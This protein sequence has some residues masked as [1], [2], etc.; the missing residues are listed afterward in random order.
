MTRRTC[1]PSVPFNPLAWVTLD[2]LKATILA[3]A[4]AVWCANRGA[5]KQS[6]QTDVAVL[7]APLQ[8]AS[9]ALLAITLSPAVAA[10]FQSS[11]AQGADRAGSSAG[12][13][14]SEHSPPGHAPPGID[15]MPQTPAEAVGAQ[16]LAI[17]RDNAGSARML[18]SLVCMCVRVCVCSWSVSAWCDDLCK[19]QRNWELRPPV[20]GAWRA[21]M[22]RSG[23]VCICVRAH[24]VCV[25]VCACAGMFVCVVRASVQ[26][27]VD[28]RDEL[29]CPR[30]VCAQKAL[31]SAAERVRSH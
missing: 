6:W 31:T 18:P 11:S 14:T 22:R 4:S 25:C 28:L 26:G 8:V 3:P 21:R 27:L 29:L 10:G 30:G 13:S 19:D 16:L 23:C 5:A 24:G 2:A 1:T 17:W 12:A 9:D 7:R 20:A 15:Q